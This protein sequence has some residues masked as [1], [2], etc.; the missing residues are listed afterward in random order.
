MPQWCS[1]PS[2]LHVVP[3][4]LS[5]WFATEAIGRKTNQIVGDIA[6]KIVWIHEEPRDVFDIGASR[7]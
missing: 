5:L 3:L 6:Y 7:Q 4:L 1:L 2:E